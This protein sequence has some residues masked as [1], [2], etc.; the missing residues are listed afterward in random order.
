[1][2]RRT[3]VT[4]TPAAPSLTPD[5][6]ARYVEKPLF[7]IPADWR[8]P[9]WRFWAHFAHLLPNQLALCMR[10]R[11]WIESDGLTFQEAV[12][13]FDYLVTPEESAKFKFAGELLAALANTVVLT[14]AN[15]KRAERARAMRSDQDPGVAEVLRQIGRSVE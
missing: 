10:L 4:P 13:A 12:R 1:M 3:E 8:I 6:V 7:M 15:R 14:M 9:A 5:D 2:E 11:D